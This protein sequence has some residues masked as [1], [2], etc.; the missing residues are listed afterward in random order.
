MEYSRRK[1]FSK[2]Q[3]LSTG[4]VALLALLAASC[5]GQKSAGLQQE[6]EAPD[7]VLY[8]NGVKY[9]QKNQFIKA[10][11]AF[12]TLI[13]TYPDSQYTPSS[14]LAIADSFYREG[15]TQNLLQAASQYNDFILFYPTHEMTDDAQMKIA[16]IYVRLMKPYDRDSTYSRKAETELKRMLKNYP[17]SELTPT[18]KE[19]LH[20]VQEN[21]AL[22][23]DAVG[24][25]YFKRG[26]Y[27][28]SINRCEEVVRNYP[29]FSKMDKT[30]YHL[31][32]SLE[33]EGLVDQAVVYYSRIAA[34]YPFSDY[35]GDAKEKLILL[36]KPVPKVDEAAAKRHEANRTEDSF[37]LLDPFRS[38]FSIFHGREDPYEL[39]RRRAEQRK[40]QE[41]RQGS[42]TNGN[43][44]PPASNHANGGNSNH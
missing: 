31:A 8:Q 20:E 3:F 7:T 5:G 25:F 22:H 6:T 33:K 34:E 41:Q 24:E 29:N 21:L 13:N 39:A 40:Q 26:A 28:A 42:S 23:D 43:G 16:A 32:E 15:G 27:K 19:L 36:E 1:T 37:S 18:A 2:S 12:Q 11:L 38:V 4:L 14:Y 9:L 30:L 44:N 10:R 17:D 35:Y